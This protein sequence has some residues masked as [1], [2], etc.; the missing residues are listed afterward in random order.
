MATAKESIY[1]FKKQITVETW[2]KNSR[3]IIIMQNYRLKFFYF[4]YWHNR[5]KT[6]RIILFVLWE[7]SKSKNGEK[8][9]YIIFDEPWL[10]KKF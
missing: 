3:S 4:F 8:K 7:P 6:G 5:V 2:K 1:L 9:N 10:F